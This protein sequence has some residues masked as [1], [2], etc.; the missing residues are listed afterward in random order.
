MEKDFIS[1]INQYIGRGDTEKAIEL[2]IKEFNSVNPI[3]ANDAL[4]YQ[5]RLSEVKRKINLNLISSEEAQREKDKINHGIINIISQSPYPKSH[6]EKFLYDW[7][8]VSIFI[9]GVAVLLLLYF[10]VD[11]GSDASDSQTNELV[12]ILEFKAGEVNSQ[13]KGIQ[14]RLG[15]NKEYYKERLTADSINNST[16]EKKED[17]NKSAIILKSL[18][19]INQFEEKYNYYHKKRVEAVENGNYILDYEIRQKMLQCILSLDSLINK[20]ELDTLKEIELLFRQ[21][22]FASIQTCSS[23]LDSTEKVSVSEYF[24]NLKISN[25]QLN[26]I[27]SV[28]YD[29]AGNIISIKYLKTPNLN[30]SMEIKIQFQLKKN[31]SFKL[32]L[33][34]L[35]KKDSNY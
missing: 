19:Q 35:K 24:R 34:S 11:K 27:D 22:Q 12:E 15:S 17:E 18:N 8:L 31:D 7:K 26:R 23:S 25:S 2:I 30:D 16:I 32:N 9:I 13:I 28:I 3:K 5:A 33:N 20:L 4:L 29:S 10:L 1:L 6:N 21:V 14:K